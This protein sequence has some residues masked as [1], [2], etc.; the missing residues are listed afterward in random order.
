[1]SRIL[2][3]RVAALA[4]TVG[5]VAGG[6]IAAVAATGSGASASG[7][8]A[9]HGAQFLKTAADYLGIS[10]GQLETKLR[11][12]QTLAQ[13]ATAEGKPAAPLMQ[14]LGQSASAQVEQRLRATAA[15]V[16]SAKHNGH[17]L[18]HSLRV[19]AAK[20]LGLAPSALAQQLRSGATLA[21]IADRTSGKSS[22]GLIE[23]LVAARLQMAAESG[24]AKHGGKAKSAAQLAK[25][26]QH[27]TA[28]VNKSHV[29]KPK[30][31]G[32][33]SRGRRAAGHKGSHAKKHS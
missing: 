9:V 31:A 11:S 30:S 10:R 4:L 25:I 7:R 5:L 33:T 19:A 24:S 2:K 6:A 13:I 20:Y 12:G 29:A 14:Q 26:R 1:M 22:S 28:F 15:R 27:I 23:A 8:S 21:Q 18:H 16:G 32:A 3:R 17:K